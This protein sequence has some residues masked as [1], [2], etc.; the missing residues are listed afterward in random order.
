[1]VLIVAACAA[2][3]LRR[4]ALPS[5]AVKGML[6]GGSGTVERLWDFGMVAPL[7]AVKI[8]VLPAAGSMDALLAG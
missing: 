2:A 1:M 5:G 6:L 3:A 4:E 8:G 7:A